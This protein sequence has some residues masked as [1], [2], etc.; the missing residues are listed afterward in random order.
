MNYDNIIKVKDLRL[1]MRANFYN[2]AE[3]EKIVSNIIIL[4]AY[5]MQWQYD[6]SKKSITITADII[7][8]KWMYISVSQYYDAVY[9][10]IY[11]YFASKSILDDGTEMCKQYIETLNNIKNREFPL[12]GLYDVR[13]IN[14]IDRG[15][16]QCE[17][18][19]TIN[20]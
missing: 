15:N 5:D 16:G 13:V 14:N 12:G 10:G 1:F 3:A 11:N 9:E 17:V 8:E 7:K 20:L 19:I 4:D 2:V 6:E 18:L